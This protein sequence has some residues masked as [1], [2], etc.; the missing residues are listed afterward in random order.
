VRLKLT[1]MTA[2]IDA[3]RRGVEPRAGVRGRPASRR[4]TPGAEAFERDLMLV[5]DCLVAAGAELACRTAFDPI[6]AAVRAHG[7]HGF[8]LDV[9]DHADVHAAALDDLAARVGLPPLDGAA[10]R[11]EL[12]G[13][14]PLSGP[15]VP[16]TADTT[17]V[18]D[19]FRAIRTIQ[20]EIGAA[21]ASTYIISMTRGPE[22]LLRVLVLAPRG[23][24][25][26]P[27]GRPAAVAAR[28]GAAVRDARRPGARPRGDARPV[29]RPG[30][31]AA[32]RARG[33]R[34]EVMIGYSDSGKDAGMLASSWALYE[35]QEALARVCREHGV[36]LR[37]F[38]GRGGSVGRGG[39]LAGRARA[40]RAAARH[41][42]RRGEDHRAG[43]DHLAAVRPRADRRAHARGH[44]RGH[45]AARV[46]GLARGARRR[47]R[48]A[49]PRGGGGALGAR[50]RVYRGLVHDDDALFALFRRATPVEELANARFGSRPAYR[51]GKTVG[52]NGI[53][54]IPWGFGWT[55]IRLMLTGW[56]GVGTALGEMAAEPDGLAL[57]QRMT[58]EWPFFD[59]LLAK[60]EMVCAKAD[61]TVART[62][63]EQLGG[64]VALLARLEDEFRRTVEVLLAVRGEERLLDDAPVLQAAI[65]LRNPYVDVLSLLQIAFLRRKRARAAGDGT[66][67]ADEAAALDHALATTLSGIAQGLRNTG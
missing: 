12:L 2:R 52:V 19:T 54:A 13:R 37:L 59:D 44:D 17:R 35:G 28:R 61:L 50:A 14:R 6:L 62:Y 8:L 7:F 22:D 64:D 23:R 40:R 45:A 66:G 10:L 55:Q 3:T 56:L 4:R 29:R 18:L 21:A 38:H 11:R 67:G 42:V 27:R 46:R 36:A 41:R 60:I 43:R 65:A 20:D 26:R 63:V 33:R 53:R 47:H 16:V 51:P 25:R 49:L 1:Y 30:V 31:R 9:R 24:P 34:Q 57:L 15:R 58:R 48:A 32:A 5:R 39:G